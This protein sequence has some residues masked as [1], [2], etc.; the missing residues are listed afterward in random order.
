MTSC[1]SKFKFPLRNLLVLI[2]LCV[3]L[4]KL[5]DI[6]LSFPIIFKIVPKPQKVGGGGMVGFV[7]F[8]KNCTFRKKMCVSVGGGGEGGVVRPP[9]DAMCL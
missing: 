2:I 6:L 5:N 9:P 8:R 3:I 1:N 4:K 7:Q